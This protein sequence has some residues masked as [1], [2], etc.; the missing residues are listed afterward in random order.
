MKSIVSNESEL[1]LQFNADFRI[2]CF[3]DNFEIDVEESIFKTWTENGRMMGSFYAVVN[4]T[5]QTNRNKRATL[6][7]DE[8]KFEIRIGMPILQYKVNSEFVAINSIEA[9]SEESRADMQEL[10]NNHLDIDL[11]IDAV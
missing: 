6:T 2:F 10:L 4:L 8:S 11:K 5:D 7:I 3:D 1:V 9:E